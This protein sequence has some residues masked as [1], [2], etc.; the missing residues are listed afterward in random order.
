M[1]LQFNQK[2]TMV[3]NNKQ[4][5]GMLV[6]LFSIL[7]FQCKSANEKSVEEV[8]S[9]K[10]PVAVPIVDSPIVP[11]TN[12]TKDTLF[13]NRKLHAK[14]VNDSVFQLEKLKFVFNNKSNAFNCQAK[15][16]NFPIQLDEV[17]A[18]PGF[19]IDQYASTTESNKYYIIIEAEGDPGTD[20]YLICKIE[21]NKLINK[22]LINEPRANSEETALKDFLSIYE[23]DGKSVFR[24]NKKKLASYSTV[25]VKIQQ[26][27]LYYY[28]SFPFE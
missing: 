11:K 16:G 21:N 6:F 7:F 25:P 2:S 12:P 4:K 15:E 20:W 14:A 9:T 8:K 22:R 17:Y 10:S 13:F 28:L 5:I 23:T 3:K 1:E 18:G 26:D 27:K 19:Q 24:F